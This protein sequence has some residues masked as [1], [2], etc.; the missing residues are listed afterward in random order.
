M[1]GR[2]GKG[3]EVEALGYS[4]R[5]AHRSLQGAAGLDVL[6]DAVNMQGWSGKWN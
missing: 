2:R 6:E 5:G 4:L 3:G 1:T